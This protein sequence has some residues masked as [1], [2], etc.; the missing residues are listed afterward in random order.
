MDF[1]DDFPILKN[2]DSETEVIDLE[3]K[4]MMP[5]FIDS[6]SHFFGVANSFLQ[7]FTKSFRQNSTFYTICSV[8]FNFGLFYYIIS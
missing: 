4:T 3:G 7:I 5:S 8:L 6:H 2:R 1:K